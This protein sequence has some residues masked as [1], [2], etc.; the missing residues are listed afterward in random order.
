MS[1]VTNVVFLLN[2]PNKENKTQQDEN[3]RYLDI[4]KISTS[5]CDI[6]IK[7]EIATS[8]EAFP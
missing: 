6:K 1:F 4:A 5:N 3:L 7:Y 2:V 8:K